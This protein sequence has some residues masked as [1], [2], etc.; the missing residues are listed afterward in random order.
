M[1]RALRSAPLRIADLEIECAVLDDA[2][3]TR[4]ISETRFMSAMGMYRSGALSTRRAKGEG[5]RAQIP[6]FL[7]YKNLK[8]FI[9]RHLT[10]EH[11]KTI[12]YVTPEGSVATEVSPIRLPNSSA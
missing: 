7:A 10:P 5:G 4:V 2:K 3:N 12:Q 6:L 9:D 11:F 8:P 1:P